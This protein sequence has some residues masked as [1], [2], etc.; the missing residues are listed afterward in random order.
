MSV[1]DGSGCAS[2]PVRCGLS[3]CRGEF[4]RA[5]KVVAIPGNGHG[6]IAPLSGSFISETQWRPGRG[7]GTSGHI[8]VRSSGTE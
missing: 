3:G 4:R 1:Q 2:V 7:R 6:D 5:S 8:T